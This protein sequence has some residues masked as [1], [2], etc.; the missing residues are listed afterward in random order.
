MAAGSMVKLWSAWLD[1]RI[2]SSM[3]RLGGV[4]DDQEAFAALVTEMIQTL[5]LVDDNADP[6]D[7]KED[8]QDDKESDNAENNE[9]DGGDS[10]NEAEGGLAGQRG[11]GELDEDG[12]YSDADGD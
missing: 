6:H 9:D 2:G 4:A 8:D 12:E 5:N 1:K 7:S 10:D 3:R 11:E